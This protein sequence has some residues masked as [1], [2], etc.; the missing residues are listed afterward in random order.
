MA[1]DQIWFSRPRKFGKGSR[2]CR[3][4]THRMG[5]IRKYGLDICRQCFREYAADIGFTKSASCIINT[6]VR[7]LHSDS[8][9]VYVHWPYCEFKCSFCNFNKYLLKDSSINP[10]SEAL[11]RETEFKTLDFSKNININSIYFGG[12]TPSLST[13]DTIHGIINQI[14]SKAYLPNDAEITIETNPTLVETSKM[15]AFREA[16][17]NRCSIGIQ[18]FDDEVLNWMNR[19]H[20]GKDAIS[21]IE[22]AKQI[23]GSGVT[24]DLLYG[25]PNQSLETLSNHLK[26]ALSLSDSHFSA[27]QLTVKNNKVVMPDSDTVMDMYNLILE[28]ASSHDLTQYEVSNFSKGTKNEGSHNKH[29]WTGG[30]Y[31]GIGPGACSH[32]LSPD[33]D[34]PEYGLSKKSIVNIRD[35]KNYIL[36]VESLNHAVAKSTLL[37]H[38]ESLN[39][40]VIFGL[41][42]KYGISNK[43][44][45]KIGNGEYSIQNFLDLEKVNQFVSQGYLEW[46]TENPNNLNSWNQKSTTLK[47]TMKGLMLADSI[48][49]DIVPF[50]ESFENSRKQNEKINKK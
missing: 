8:V 15:K 19:H 33:P 4:C 22:T 37:S 18:S 23:F 11:I 39:Q 6:S 5:L 2:Q 24:F 47:P 40:L 13:P 10:I 34:H 42:S 17:I 35:P 16:G 20:S 25:I 12:G 32:L 1:H 44:F 30:D 3:V 50:V 38:Y 21:A 43:S 49:P 48:I 9:S 14:S 7:S 36:S 27:Y 45:S 41:R 46:G 28:I 26:L 31:I 29:Y